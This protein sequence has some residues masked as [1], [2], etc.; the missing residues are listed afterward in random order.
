MLLHDHV[1]DA[2]EFPMK[3]GFECDNL[4]LLIVTD[5][6]GDRNFSINWILIPDEK[7]HS[8]G[9]LTEIRHD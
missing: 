2:V 3:I 7:S 4:M 1:C 6:N 5:S 9:R 8:D